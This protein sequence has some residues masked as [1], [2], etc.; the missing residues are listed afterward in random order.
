MVRKHLVQRAVFIG[1]CGAGILLSTTPGGAAGKPKKPNACGV[2]YQSAL[3][4]QQS[5][6]LRVARETFSRCASPACGSVSKKCAAAVTQ[7][8]TQI[9]SVIPVVTNE[10]GSPMADVQV[11]VDGELWAQHLDGR[12]VPIDPGV[13]DF[14]FATDRGV[15]LA[16]QKVM[17]LQGQRGPL[18]FSLKGV[19]KGRLAAS[20]PLASTAET[21]AETQPVASVDQADKGEKATP[22]TLEERTGSGQWALPRSPFPYVL[23][24]VGLAAVGAGTLLTVWGNKDNDLALAQCRGTCPQSTV[25]HIKMTYVEADISFGVGIAA[26]AVTTWLFA[27]SRGPE[28]KLQPRAT[29]AFDVTPV[30]S[31]AVASLSGAF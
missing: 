20:T 30:R 2:T 9:P 16:T 19:Q 29:A 14:S 25:D 15:F 11:T 13:H 1:A 27:G 21:K 18:S 31:G 8:E 7:L 17:I 23:G 28:D 6:H 12:A 10:E 3:E 22:E 4:E 5:D 24:A 26:L